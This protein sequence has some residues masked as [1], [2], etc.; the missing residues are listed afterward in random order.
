MTNLRMEFPSIKGEPL[1]SRCL[2]APL[3]RAPSSDLAVVLGAFMVG[4][5]WAL[6]RMGINLTTRETSAYQ[7]VWRH[8]GCVRVWL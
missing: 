2:C 7:S 4:P 8:V 3:T 5:V 1:A 6:R